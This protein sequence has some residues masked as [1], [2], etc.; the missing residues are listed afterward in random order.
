MAE[1]PN[2]QARKLMDWPPALRLLGFL[3]IVGGIAGGFFASNAEAELSR[4]LG[5]RSSGATTWITW[6]LS[7]AAASILWFALAAI[8]EHVLDLHRKLDNLT[9]PQQRT[10]PVS[11]GS[12]RSQRDTASQPTGQIDWPD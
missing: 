1:T 10:S 4:L 3:T 6:A 11:T 9:R 5:T 7:G 12:H 2:V 8:M